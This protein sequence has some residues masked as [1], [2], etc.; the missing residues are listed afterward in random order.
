MGRVLCRRSGMVITQPSGWVPGGGLAKNRR[1]SGP[2]L[3]LRV[4]PGCGR[5]SR[6]APG[7]T[8]RH[9]SNARLGF[10]CRATQ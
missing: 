7:G 1:A 10:A 5:L 8:V 6:S 3:P 9:D 2:N 4:R